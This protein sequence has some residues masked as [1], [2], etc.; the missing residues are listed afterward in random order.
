VYGVKYYFEV[1]PRLAVWRLSAY[2]AA[3]GRREVRDL[4]DLVTVHATILPL[5]AV[6][7]AAVEKSPGF[8]P[9][10]LIAEIRRNANYPA[11]D[12]RALLSSEPID[13]KD[14]ASRLRSALDEAESFVTGMPTDKMGLLFLKGGQVVQP[15]PARLP[16]YQT[17][18]GQRRGQWPSSPEITAAMFERYRK[19]PA[20]APPDVP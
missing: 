12:W 2:L 7:W 17:H 19:P 20:P 16:G 9:E 15:D 4:V 13:P 14:I 8:T 10:G 3:A 1:P 11:A 5:G 6:V 18:A